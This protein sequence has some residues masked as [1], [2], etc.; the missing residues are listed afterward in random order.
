MDHQVDTYFNVPAGRL[1]LREGNI[2]NNLIFYERPDTLEPK[3]SRVLLEPV[4]KNS[5]LGKIFK[6]ILG[7]MIH[8]EKKREIYFIDHVKIHLDEVKNLGSFL[9]I[10]VINFKGDFSIKEMQDTCTYFMDLFNIYE[11][12]LEKK[13]Y[14]DLLNRDYG[15]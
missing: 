7:I 9:E 15:N 14:S 1:K 3:E 6:K 4:R 11:K 2:E 12:D 13:S 8:V 10:E 5:S